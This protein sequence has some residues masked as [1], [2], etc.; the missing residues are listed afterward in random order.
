M[1]KLHTNHGTMRVTSLKKRTVLL[2]RKIQ[3]KRDIKD[4]EIDGYRVDIDRQER[5]DM[6]GTKA[7]VLKKNKTLGDYVP[8]EVLKKNVA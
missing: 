5:W 4:L 2:V 3:D 7:L 6:R 1:L 8:P